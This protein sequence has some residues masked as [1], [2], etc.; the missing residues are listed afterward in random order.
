MFINSIHVLYI[1][2]EIIKRRYAQSCEGCDSTISLRMLR[3]MNETAPNDPLLCNTCSRVRIIPYLVS[4][5]SLYCFQFSTGDNGVIFLFQLTKL[6]H[7]C[8]ICKKIWNRSDTVSWVRNLIKKN[9]LN[10]FSFK[11]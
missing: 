2:Q 1:L 3:K 5:D 4:C 10:Y 11:N 8:G 6:K 9:F 7:N